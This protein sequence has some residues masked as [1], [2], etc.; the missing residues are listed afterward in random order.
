MFTV[1]RDV[2]AKT[3]TDPR[4]IDILVVNCSLF[5][6][7]PSLASMIINEFG[8]RTDI[9][10]YNLS[11]MGCS[12]GLI[13][14]E[15][16]KNILAGRPH[17]TALVVS[18]EIITPNL[19]HGEEKSFLLQ[20]TLFRCGGAAVILSNKWIDAYRASCK[21]LYVIRTQFVS[22]DSFGCVYETEDVKN[23]RGVRLSKDIVKIAGRAME[24]NFTMLG[25][26]ALPLSEQVK[27]AFWMVVRFDPA[28]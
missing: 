2:L 17:S 28:R 25:P 8:M 9:S 1:V 7:T 14:I 24:R 22:E 15:L 26:Y 18:T 13:S 19:Y 16:V 6:P 12:A 4:S 27:T 20:N 23:Q 3:K 10:S 21:L 5:A 11:G